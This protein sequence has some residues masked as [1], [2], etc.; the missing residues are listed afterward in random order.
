MSISTNQLNTEII[1][2]DSDGTPIAESDL[3]RDYLI[4]CVEALDIYFQ[5]GCQEALTISSKSSLTIW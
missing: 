3:A 2:L 5:D 4:Y 1:Y